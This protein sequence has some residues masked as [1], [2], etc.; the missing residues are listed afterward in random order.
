MTKKH[1]NA[2]QALKYLQKGNTAF[3]NAKLSLISLRKTK[4]ESYFEAIDKADFVLI[5][6]NPFINFDALQ[7]LNPVVIIG[8]NN[9]PIKVQYFIKEFEKRG[10]KYYN[11]AQQGAFIVGN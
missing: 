5:S 7:R 3:E 1:Y 6:N 11:V 10:I 8:S 4:Q 9:K 2:T